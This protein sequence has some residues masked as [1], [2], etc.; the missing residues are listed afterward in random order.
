MCLGMRQQ[1]ESSTCHKLLLGYEPPCAMRGLVRAAFTVTCALGQILAE[2]GRDDEGEGV[3]W[4]GRE[5]G[6]EWE[7]VGFSHLYS[8][9][10][11]VV[12]MVINGLV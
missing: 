5:P 4:V 7:G 11:L 12:E 1:H 10:L 3:G 6:R 9:R 2:R 8:L